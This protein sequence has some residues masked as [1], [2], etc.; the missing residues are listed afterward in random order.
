MKKL[1]MGIILDCL[2]YEK[3]L[4]YLNK[5]MYITRPEWDGYHYRNSNGEYCIMLKDETI[6]VEPN[7]IHDTDKDDWM[8]VMLNGALTQKEVEPKV[9]KNNI[10]I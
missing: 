9:Y 2:T 4:E 8:V 7:E 10:I 5:G 6:L 3:A 1:Y